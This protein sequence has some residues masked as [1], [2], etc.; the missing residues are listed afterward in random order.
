MFKCVIDCISVPDENRIFTLNLKGKPIVCYSI[1][2]ALDSG[3]FSK[4]DVLT[5]S[6]Y[7]S[8]MC[9][10]IY[11]DRIGILRD[12]KDVDYP[13]VILSGRAPFMGVKELCE[14]VKL[15]GGGVNLFAAAKP[16]SHGGLLESFVKLVHSYC[17]IPAAAYIY[18]P[19][20]AKYDTFYLNGN[21]GIIINTSNDFELALV[22]KVKEDKAE[23]LRTKI[24]ERILEKENVFSADY[25]GKSVALIGHSH[26][27]NWNVD[28]LLDYKAIN[29]G[30]RGI[31]SFEYYDEI[32]LKNKI[33]HLSDAYIIMHGT[34]DIINNVSKKDVCKSILNTINYIRQRTTAPIFFVLCA[35]VNGRL[36]RD[37]DRITELNSYISKE[38]SG[39]V[40]IIN[41]EKM[42]DRFG[43]LKKEFTIDGLHFSTEGYL[44]FKDIVE[45]EMGKAGLE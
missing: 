4:V 36:D 11:G 16:I 35:H 37:N 2:T 34:N 29:Y 15:C 43:N 20:D 45:S 19:D 22:L 10:S 41:L 44:C 8:E 27:D 21:A 1:D 25:A 42:D 38:L 17:E 31:N 13:S 9:K 30:I 23:K 28:S 18:E 7:I 40:Y 33:R 14:F 39:K 6:D 3:L 26:I 24:R 32:I 12:I 5:Q